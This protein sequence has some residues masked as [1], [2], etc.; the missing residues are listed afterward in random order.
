[1][2]KKLTIRKKNYT[3]KAGARNYADE[4]SKVMKTTMKSNKRRVKIKT[5]RYGK[6]GTYGKPTSRTVTKRVIRK[7]K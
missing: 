4:P 7:K 6:T 1:M 2:K 3:T 5:V